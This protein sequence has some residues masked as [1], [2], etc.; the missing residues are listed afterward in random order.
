MVPSFE[1]LDQVI[2][3]F[4]YVFATAGFI[5]GFLS[6]KS[7]VRLAPDRHQPRHPTIES[8]LEIDRAVSLD[9]REENNLGSYDKDRVLAQPVADE[10]KIS[11]STNRGLVKLR[12]V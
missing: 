4:G 12:L 3:V 8:H 5:L 1:W 2:E 9:R 11:R 6:P 7:L 10:R